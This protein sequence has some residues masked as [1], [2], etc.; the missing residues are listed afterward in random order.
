MCYS[1]D[2]AHAPACGVGSVFGVGARLWFPVL[3]SSDVADVPSDGCELKE[4]VVR[5]RVLIMRRLIVSLC[6]MCCRCVLPFVLRRCMVVVGGL[7]RRL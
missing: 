3:V 4:V 5:V 6:I 7:W 1:G 2:L